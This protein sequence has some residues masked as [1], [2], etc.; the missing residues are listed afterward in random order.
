MGV[1]LVAKGHFVVLEGDQSMIGNGD[2]VGV[3]GEV[4]QDMLGATEGRFKIDDPVL[5]EQGAQERGEGWRLTEGLEGSG[6][7]KLGMAFF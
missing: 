7:S 3:A 6:E 4:A 2:P 5:A 1:V